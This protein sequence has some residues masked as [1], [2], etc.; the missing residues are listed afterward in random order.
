[1]DVLPVVRALLDA[2]IPGPGGRLD[3][4]SARAQRAVTAAA[5]SRPGRRI[6]PALRGDEWLGRPLHPFLVPVPILAWTAGA[7]QDWR[8]VRVGDVGAQRRGDVLL[9]VGLLG[10]AI[11]V[12]TGQAQF[13]DASGVARRETALHV[14]LVGFVL[15]LQLTSLTARHRGRRRSAR[16]LSAVSVALLPVSGVLGIDQAARLQKGH[17]P[18]GLNRSRA[19]SSVS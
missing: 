8:G 19:A 7:Y 17:Y 12:L 9:K 15:G 3:R 14:A 11:A 10:V 13:P 16:R 1:M 6:F 18:D 4:G 2:A 5:G